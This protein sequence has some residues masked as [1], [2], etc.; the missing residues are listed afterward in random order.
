MH[1]QFTLKSD[2]WSFGI[3][4]YEVGTQGKIPYPEMTNAQ[5]LESLKEG[6]CMPPSLINRTKWSLK[7]YDTMKDCWRE[8]PT[9]RP[10]FKTLKYVI[11]D[12]FTDKKECFS[13]QY[14]G[15]W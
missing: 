9:S 4:M 5:V 10:T 7:L 3:V 13:G 8:N 6:Y 15:L 2:V 11:E 14:G 1:G 12:L